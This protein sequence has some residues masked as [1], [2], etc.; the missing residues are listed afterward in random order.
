MKEDFTIVT[1]LPGNKITREQLLRLYQRYHF[2]LQ[3]CKDKEVLEV[4]CGGGMGLGYLSQVAKKIVGGDIDELNLK[5]AI[6]HYKGNGKIELRIIDAHE[7][8]FE[9]NNFDV[10]ILYEALYY[11]N[12]PERFIKEA[13]RILRNN[14]V[15]LICTV[16][17]D[18]S[19]FNPS[20]YSKKYFSATELYSLVS[21]Y[22][23]SVELYGAIPISK[24]GIK[25]TIIS[26]I[27]RI[28]I[29]FHLIP[30]TM[31]GKEKFKRIFFGK[32][33]VMPAE[34][35]EGMIDYSPPVPISSN[36]PD[37]K[38]K[39]LFVVAHI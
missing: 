27:K 12:Q 7:L 26:Y 29:A 22:F 15:L 24:S 32:L 16:N 33:L 17:R 35:V 11:L 8:P 13:R 25:D 1:E 18:W 36:Y 28:A 34:I 2:A 10:V 39:V 19:D 38:H 14:G 5:Y 21:Q 6:E 31:K 20:S 23:S 3:F 4:A 30:K 37:Y 9:N